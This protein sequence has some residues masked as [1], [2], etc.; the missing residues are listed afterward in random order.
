[1]LRNPITSQLLLCLCRLFM[2][3]FRPSAFFSCPSL[4]IAHTSS[5]S[6]YKNSYLRGIHFHDTQ[7]SYDFSDIIV[8]FFII[9]R[10]PTHVGSHKRGE[11]LRQQMA[12]RKSVFWT[13]RAKATKHLS[14]SV[15]FIYDDS[16]VLSLVFARTFHFFFKSVWCSGAW[17]NGFK[18][19]VCDSF[20]KWRVLGC[21]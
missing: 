13:S 14:T 2:S 3:Y 5:S 20:R 7:N 9:K 8:P 10:T 16:N 17:T 12:Q 11:T 6:L 4:S 18:L 19:A 15:S 21:N 1:M